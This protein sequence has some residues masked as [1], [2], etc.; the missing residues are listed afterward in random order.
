MDFFR[1]IVKIK[2]GRQ[3]DKMNLVKEPRVNGSTEDVDFTSATETESSYESD[4]GVIDL[5]RT[6]RDP[7][8]N[9]EG[10]ASTKVAHLDEEV[11]E[12][13]NCVVGSA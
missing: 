9:V 1:G 10:N 7:F 6:N 12:A 11:P 13:S 4:H 3:E 2:Y 5:I 8:G